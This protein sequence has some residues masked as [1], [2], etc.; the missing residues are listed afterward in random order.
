MIPSHLTS[1]KAYIGE[2]V[3]TNLFDL[4]V[5]MSCKDDPDLHFFDEYV[6]D[7]TRYREREVISRQE[8]R[9]ILGG[10]EAD[11][12]EAST[13]VL[14][15]HFPCNSQSEEADEE[16]EEEDAPI[17]GLFSSVSFLRVSLS[18]FLSL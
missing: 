17:G 12:L 18:L 13:E 3:A 10:R 14:H 9:T 16:E 2:F 6:Q 8:L 1:R 7:V 11:E 4:F 15:L 5:R